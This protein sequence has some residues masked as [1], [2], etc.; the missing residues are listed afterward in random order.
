[1]LFNALENFPA[2]KKKARLG[3]EMDCEFA[4]VLQNVL[5]ALLAIYEVFSSL[6][7]L[8]HIWLKK[9]GLMPGLRFPI[10]NIQG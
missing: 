1:L 2:I 3:L 5:I 9:R 8:F 6:V 7:P 10:I 4:S